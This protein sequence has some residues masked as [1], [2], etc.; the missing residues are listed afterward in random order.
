VNTGLDIPRIIKS[1]QGIVPLKSGAFPP[2]ANA[3]REDFGNGVNCGL[4]IDMFHHNSLH[5]GYIPDGK[6]KLRNES[7]KKPD[8]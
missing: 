2:A 7:Q 1:F 4:I 3:P 5:M 6:Q 8:Y